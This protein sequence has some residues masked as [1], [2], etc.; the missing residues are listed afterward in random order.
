MKLSPE[1]TDSLTLKFAQLARE[2]NQ[3]GH[4]IISLGLG[5]PEF[6]TPG[7]II[8]ATIIAL[9]SGFTRYSNPKGLFELRKLIAKKLILENAIETTPD[10]IIVTPGAK[11]ASPIALMSILLLFKY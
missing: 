6:L 8:E 7:S 11:Q 2:K 1:V 4:K 10:N 3:A 5:E 9:R